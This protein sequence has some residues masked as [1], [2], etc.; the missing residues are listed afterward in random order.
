[1]REREWCP[2]IDW[3]NPSPSTPKYHV[4][5]L[6]CLHDIPRCVASITG[7]KSHRPNN[8]VNAVRSVLL[9]YPAIILAS[10]RQRRE[11]DVLVFG[12]VGEPIAM[13]STW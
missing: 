1:M 10:G 6:L 4:K 9:V 12:N 2:Q 11:P 5:L 3:L 8:G 7:E 13:T